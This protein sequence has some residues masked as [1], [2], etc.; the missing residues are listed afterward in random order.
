MKAY[1]SDIH[2][3]DQ[4][5]AKR[6][7][8]VKQLS[9]INERN[10]ELL[11]KFV[12]DCFAERLTAGRVYKHIYHMLII[13]RILGKDADKADKDDIKRLMRTIETSNS[14]H[15]KPYS[16]HTKKDFR[17]TV[18][19]FYK[20]LNNGVCPDTVSWIKIDIK[21]NQKRLPE[22]ILSQ[23]EI[24]GLIKAANNPRDKALIFVLYET[25][26]RIGEIVD[27]M[28][29]HIQFDKYGA[30][31]IVNGKTGPRRVRLITS[32]DY[33]RYWLENHP[34][35]KN[36]DAYLWVTIST[37][38]RGLRLPY[39]AVRKILKQ[40]ANK[41]GIHKKV[42]PHSFRHARATHLAGKLTEIQLCS[43]FGWTLSS[44][45]PATYVHMSG[46]DMDGALLKIY[47]LKQDGQ[48]ET[49]TCPRCK[50]ENKP[51]AKYCI[52]CGMPLSLDIALKDQE[53]RSKYDDVMSKL[54]ENEK[55]KNIIK[56]VLGDMR[57]SS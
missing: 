26:C 7:E 2:Q 48:E 57:S 54:M 17:I 19:K 12:D 43:L 3:Y 25:G 41:A 8:K 5:V 35:R 36:P 16:E 4:K 34:D 9:D 15:Q 6:I 47:G 27:M 33:L 38:R 49:I 14:V 45:M 39:T 51:L 53:E 23:E 28:V 20:W 21:N 11:L 18:K 37:N 10:K 22:E 50:H 24:K 52:E 13:V 1:M 32:C 30:Q 40:T 31:M 42:N 44:R 55:V 56:E 46:R 29:K